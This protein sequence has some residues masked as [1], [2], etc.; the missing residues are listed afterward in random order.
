M[1]DAADATRLAR[2]P[3]PRVDFFL[4]AMSPYSWL[5]AERIGKLLPHAR[6][7]ALFLGG[8]FHGAGRQSWG[9]GERREQEMAECERRAAAYGLGV[10]R[11]PEPW[12]TNDLAVARAMTFA[13]REGALRRFA[14]A[15]MRLAFLAGRD[16]E[17]PDTVLEAAR[18]AEIDPERVRRALG[19]EEIKLAL[20][21]ETDAALARGVFGVPTVAVG[22]QLFW[23]E[24]RLEQAAGAAGARAADA[25]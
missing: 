12:P 7:R 13:D 23:G 20:R 24:D 11:W 25:G 4:G 18:V 22:E 14:L 5:A 6:W 2:Q 16:L 1:R 17:R 15:A 9:F 3:E 8:L 10:M 19:D 21:S